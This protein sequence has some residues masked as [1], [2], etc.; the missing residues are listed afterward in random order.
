MCTYQTGNF[1][2]WGSE[3]VK[4]LDASLSRR[5][6]KTGDRRTEE[7]KNH[8]RSLGDRRTEEPLK[9]RSAGAD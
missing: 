1:T 6:E 3:G 4:L 7:Q 2:G 5:Q 9:Y 8:F